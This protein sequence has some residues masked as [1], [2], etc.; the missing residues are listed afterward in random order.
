MSGVSEIE[1]SQATGQSWADFGPISEPIY[2]RDIRQ[3]T[4]FIGMPIIGQGIIGQYQACKVSIFSLSSVKRNCNQDIFERNFINVF[5][6]STDDVSSRKTKVG[7]N[8]QSWPY[9]QLN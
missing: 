8:L 4:Q 2:W 1:Y 3:V 6:K 5:L 7:Q 9:E